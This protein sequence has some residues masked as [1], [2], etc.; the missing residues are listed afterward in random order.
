VVT[1]LH[2]PFKKLSYW[3]QQAFATALVERMLPN[4]QMFSAA[5]D[6]GDAALL[7]NQLSLFWQFLGDKKVRLNAEAQQNKLEPNIPDANVFE[8]YGVYPAIDAAMGLMLLLESIE[9]HSIDIGHEVSQLSLN[10]VQQFIAMQ[11]GEPLSNAELKQHPLM[12]WE[13]ATQNELF[14]TVKQAKENKASCQQ[15]IAMV[16]EAGMSNLAIDCQF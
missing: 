7:R 14:D 4:Y 11:H 15:L 9:D 2:L 5:M 16:H 10:C 3:Q 1:V 8:V 6:F 12:A 13:I